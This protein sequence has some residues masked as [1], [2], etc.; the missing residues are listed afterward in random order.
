V[1][2]SYADRVAESTATTGT[3]TLT[4]GGALNVQYQAFSSAFANA[5]LVDYCIF[6]PAGWEVGTGV[7]TT[8]GTTLTRVACASSNSNALVSLTGTSTVICTVAAAKI[9]NLPV[10]IAMNM[11]GVMQ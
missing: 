10:A 8:S 6:G 7:Y 3:G 2:G 4:L 9:V 11:A 5:T 1:A